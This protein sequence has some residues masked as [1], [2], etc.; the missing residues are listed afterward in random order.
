MLFFFENT[1]YDGLTRAQDG[2]SRTRSLRNKTKARLC[3]AA[4]TTSSA[5]PATNHRARASGSRQTRRSPQHIIVAGPHHSS[6]NRTAASRPNKLVNKSSAAG[7]HRI[8]ITFISIQQSTAAVAS[9]LLPVQRP[10]PNSSEAAVPACLSSSR[11]AHHFHRTT[12][13]PNQATKRDRYPK[14]NTNAFIRRTVP[15]SF[16]PKPG[17]SNQTERR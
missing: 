4:T 1:R 3:P 8:R 5:G 2:Y 15:G 17:E 14:R 9:R 6:T 16:T 13:S 11:P 10:T 7:T 12:G